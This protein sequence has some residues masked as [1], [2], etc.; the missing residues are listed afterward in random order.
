MSAPRLNPEM[1][2]CRKKRRYSDEA[3]A[4]AGAMIQTQNG[5]VN[6]LYVYRCR[7]C[8][9][10][11]LTRNHQGIRHKVTADNP[12]HSPLET[13]KDYDFRRPDQ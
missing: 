5:R 13:E 6:A 1:A 7:W 11:H 10:W 8:Q 4:R 9:G 2:K 3:T 12:V